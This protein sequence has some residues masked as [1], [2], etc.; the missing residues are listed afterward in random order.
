MMS[1]CL[2]N[3]FQDAWGD[4]VGKLW[5]SEMR[6]FNYRIYRNIK[7][8]WQ[9]DPDG[10]TNQALAPHIIRTLAHAH[11]F[12]VIVQHR[13]FTPDQARQVAWLER[14]WRVWLATYRWPNWGRLVERLTLFPAIYL[15]VSPAQHAYYRTTPATPGH[16]MA[17]KLFRAEE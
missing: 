5:A 9:A 6:M 14:D 12:G 7:D 10:Y 1:D 17:L 15:Q 8:H 11:H 3:A 4:Q 13:V 2:F 16:F